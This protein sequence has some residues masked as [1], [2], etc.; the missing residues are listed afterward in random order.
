MA[1]LWIDSSMN[2]SVASGGNSFFSLMTGFA[3]GDT[4]L[5]RMTLIRTIIGLNV[6]Y[7]VHDSGEG[8][9]RASLGIAIAEQSAFTAGSLPSP[10]LVT[11]FPRLPWVWRAHYR[12]FGFAA[13]QPAVYSQRVDLDIRSQ[14]K[15][16]NGI[17]FIK[18]NN[19]VQE[20]VAS[21]IEVTGLIRM[22]W[23]VG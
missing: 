5:A 8:S 21:T 18:I 11:S 1:T 12:V 2:A 14:R 10:N 17:A 7:T 13:D 4:R 15:L 6:G 22:L 9:Q 16:E 3:A 20:G 19:D 23:L